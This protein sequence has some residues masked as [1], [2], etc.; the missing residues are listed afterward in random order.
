LITDSGTR[1][2]VPQ[3]DEAFLHRTGR[4]RGFDARTFECADG[5]TIERFTVAI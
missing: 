4:A 1:G 2:A 5:N 3:A